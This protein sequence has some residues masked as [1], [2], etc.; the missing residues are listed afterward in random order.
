MQNEFTVS[1]GDAGGLMRKGE[2]VAV[3]WVNPHDILSPLCWYIAHERE[4]S[5]IMYVSRELSLI[6]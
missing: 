3:V 6:F 5:L 4:V 1:L 2:C